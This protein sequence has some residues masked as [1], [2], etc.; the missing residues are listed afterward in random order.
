MKLVKESN[1][2][3]GLD[4]CDELLPDLTP[5]VDVLFPATVART[6]NPEHYTGSCDVDE[7]LE[8]RTLT[9]ILDEI[10]EEVVEEAT[11]DEYLYDYEAN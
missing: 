11:K 6:G 8:D 1:E 3:T 9:A 4:F 10:L 7:I 2:I 5:L